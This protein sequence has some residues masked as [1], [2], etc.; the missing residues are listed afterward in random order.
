[1]TFVWAIWLELAN[2]GN[3]RRIW[4]FL[5]LIKDVRGREL[6]PES[7]HSFAGKFKYA[8]KFMGSSKSVIIRS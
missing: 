7:E 6:E 3:A 4:Q 8:F 2:P 5:I 1:M